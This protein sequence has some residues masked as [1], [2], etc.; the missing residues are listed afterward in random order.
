MTEK[1]ILLINFFCNQILQILI[2]FLCENLVRGSTP[3]PPASAERGVHNMLN[4]NRN[5]G[6]KLNTNLKGNK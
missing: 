1:N 4:L 5:L 3:P 6:I 2:Y